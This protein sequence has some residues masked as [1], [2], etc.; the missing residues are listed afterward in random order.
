MNNTK[1]IT[2]PEFPNYEINSLGVV[3][4]R[5]RNHV[6]AIIYRDGLTPYIQL[7]KQNKPKN[8]PLSQ[9]VAA[10]FLPK[11]P[12]YRGFMVY[13]KDRNPR[14]CAASNLEWRWGKVS[15]AQCEKVYKLVKNGK[16][17]DE[18]AQLLPMRSK[19][20]KKI[21]KVQAIVKLFDA[22]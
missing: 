9:L 6:K 18:V 21:K 15:L 10:H 7:Y 8:L 16:P 3:R 19:M 17:V 14:N 20:F 5:G 11:P 1:W 4:V 22:R 12:N 13:T 2:I